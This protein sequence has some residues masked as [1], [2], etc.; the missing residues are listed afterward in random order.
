MGCRWQKS[1]Y[2]LKVSLQTIIFEVDET[3]RKFE[4]KE[5]EEDNSAYAKVQEWK[6]YFPHPVYR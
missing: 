6:I 5:N 4:F 1:I 3:I 2:G